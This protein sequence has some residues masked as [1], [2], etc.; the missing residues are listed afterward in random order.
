M[1]NDKDFKRIPDDVIRPDLNGEQWDEH[2]RQSRS[3]RLWQDLQ[4]LNSTTPPGIAYTMLTDENGQPTCAGRGCGRCASCYD[5][6]L[7]TGVDSYTDPLQFGWKHDGEVIYFIPRQL[8]KGRSHPQLDITPPRD[9]QRGFIAGDIE[10]DLHKKHCYGFHGLLNGGFKRGEVSLFSALGSV[11]H[12]YH[13]RTSILADLVRAAVLDKKKVISVA[14][15]DSPYLYKDSNV[16][17]FK[18][19]RRSLR[20]ISRT[21]FLDNS[22]IKPISSKAMEKFE[23]NKTY[24]TLEFGDLYV[25]GF[26]IHHVGWRYGRVNLGANGFS[27]WLAN[28]KN[29]GFSGATMGGDYY[30]L[31]GRRNNVYTNDQFVQEPHGVGFSKRESWAEEAIDRLIYLRL[32]GD[33]TAPVWNER[34]GRWISLQPTGKLATTLNYSFGARVYA[35]KMAARDRLYKATNPERS[36]RGY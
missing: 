15:E 25:G 10:I 21:R 5:R 1:S 14:M 33:V 27:D 3:Q 19:G 17:E 31:Y 26:R 29:S 9:Y 30:N 11:G 34:L 16:L 13:P 2:M 35:E 36:K 28:S 20:K 18:G 7:S 6:Q 23:E 22:I 8:G 32:Y 12:T 4:E 24:I